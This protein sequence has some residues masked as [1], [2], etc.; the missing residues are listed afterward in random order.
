[1]NRGLI[2]ALHL[3]THEIESSP[4]DRQAHGAAQSCAPET[5]IVRRRDA[6]PFALEVR[7]Q[8]RS[9]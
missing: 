9:A 8:T 4:A 5:P 7:R 6:K 1:M 2:C 3:S